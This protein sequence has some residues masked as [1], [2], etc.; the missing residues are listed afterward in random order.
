[1]L[2]RFITVLPRR[3]CLLISWLQSPSA[4]ILKPEKIKSV[5]VSTVSPSTCY[6]VIGLDA[7]ILVFWMLNFKPSFSLSSFTFIKRLFS[8][9]L[10]HIRVVSSVYLNLLTFLPAILLTACASSSPAFRMMDSAYKLNKQGD[11]I[12]PW[13]IPFPIWTQSIFPC[14]VISVASW[15]AYR[16][17]RRQIRWSGTPISFR[18][19]HSP[20]PIL[21]L[22]PPLSSSYPSGMIQSTNFQYPASCIEFALVIYFAYGNVPFGKMVLMILSMWKILKEDH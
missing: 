17:L 22:L 13:C 11:N 9:S 5:I 10:S 21:K 12:Q 18:I 16:F 4:V 19:F 15:P 3:K 7:I 6:E 2:S 8:S 1:M 14:P 20:P